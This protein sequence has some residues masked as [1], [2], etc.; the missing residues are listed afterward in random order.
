MD[1][2]VKILIFAMGFCVGAIHVVHITTKKLIE[3][4]KEKENEHD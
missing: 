1:I 2:L 3:I 4:Y